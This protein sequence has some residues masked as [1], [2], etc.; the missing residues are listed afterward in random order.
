M[1]SEIVSIEG[2]GKCYRIGARRERS[3][4]LR[5]SVTSMAVGAA[6]RLGQLVTRRRAEPRSEDFWALKDISLE[7]QRGEVCG[8]IGRNGAGKSTLLKILSRITEPTE[9]RAV[10]RGRVGSLLEVGTGF[11]P[12]LTGRE[13]IYMSGAI[14]GMRKAEIQRKFDGIVAFADIERFLDT[15]CKRY[16]SGMYVR[17][18]FAVAAHLEPEILIIDEVLAVGDAAFQKKCLGKMS[19]VSRSG[20]TVLFVS[21]NMRVVNKLCTRAV[22]LADGRVVG[23]GSPQQI[24][25]QY[26]AEAATGVE[27]VKEFEWP[28]ATDNAI[29]RLELLDGT[30]TPGTALRAGDK[31]SAKVHFSTRR[32]LPHGIVGCG[33]STADG[34]P[35]HTF[36]SQ[37]QDFQVGSHTAIFHYNQVQLS[38]GTY[39]LTLGLSSH[40]RTVHY[41]EDAAF[42]QLG[43]APA[44]GLLAIRTT[45]TG[46]I[47]NSVRS[48]VE[49]RPTGNSR[50]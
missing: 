7:V 9:G 5:E 45:G 29:T 20:R 32:P 15:P 46:L 19:E 3:L 2:L 10:L 43:E 36:W 14:L 31:W 16:S 48:V 28:A 4:S 41:L 39:R 17:L 12:E 38:A 11:H 33:I 40:E 30:G 8:I 34:V 27:A 24:T 37:P 22:L 23:D 42:I 18:G 13:N 49:S 44:E 21:H 6:R 50:P 26:L 47:L 25:D 35:V 1:S